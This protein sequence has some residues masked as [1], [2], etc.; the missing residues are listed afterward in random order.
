M[1]LHCYIDL[2]ERMCVCVCVYCACACACAICVFFWN[3]YQHRFLFETTIIPLVAS[4]KVHNTAPPIWKHVSDRNL[5]LWLRDEIPPILLCTAP[6]ST[7]ATWLNPL[8]KW[9]PFSWKN[10]W[11]TS[12]LKILTFSLPHFQELEGSSYRYSRVPGALRKCYFMQ[13]V[14]SAKTNIWRMSILSLY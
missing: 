3:V 8:S 6:I 5:Y 7:N 9:H 10:F 2:G 11:G 4:K 1:T 12:A 13:T 14:N